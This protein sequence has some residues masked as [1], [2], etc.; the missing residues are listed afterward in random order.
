M[1]NIEFGFGDRYTAKKR[2]QW[3]YDK[4][5]AKTRVHPQIAKVGKI[6]ILF[7]LVMWA[8]MALINAW[9]DHTIKST[10]YANLVKYHDING[11]KP[12]H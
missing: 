6:A 8:F 9:T 4:K 3:F 11:F 10:Q 5:L 12:V 2:I 7:L 1:E